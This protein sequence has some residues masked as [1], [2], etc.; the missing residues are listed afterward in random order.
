MQNVVNLK[1]QGQEPVWDLA[2][3]SDIELIGAGTFGKDIGTLWNIGFDPAG[4]VSVGRVFVQFSNL[5]AWDPD[6]DKDGCNLGSRWGIL[7]PYAMNLKIGKIDPGVVPHVISEESF[8]LLQF[9]AMPTD[10]F[11][12]GQTGFTLFAEQPAVELNG[13][14]HQYWSYTV[15]FANGGSAVAL[16]S[17]DNTFKDVYFRVARK[18]F[19]SPLDGVIVAPAQAEAGQAAQAD[20][21]VYRMPG[22][23]FW[24]AVSLETGVFGWF[25]KSNIPNL[26]YLAANNLTYNPSDS[27]TFVNDYFQRVGVDRG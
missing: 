2:F 8:P 1:P 24:R 19:G 4:G 22:L 17:D 20:D 13:I 14:L 23:D 25:G 18:W 16:P 26:P 7:P 9:P 6:E 5:F 15:G 27:S 21:S 11:T 3:P 12:L 10:T